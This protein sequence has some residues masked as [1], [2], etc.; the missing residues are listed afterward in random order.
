MYTTNAAHDLIDDLIC[1]V[2]RNRESAKN[3]QQHANFTGAAV[4][5]AWADATQLV[6]DELNERLAKIEDEARLVPETD[7]PFTSAV[8]WLRQEMAGDWRDM[9][10]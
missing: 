6:V 1:R 4:Y 2:E 7:L 10:A 3:A 5:E 9:P 8:E